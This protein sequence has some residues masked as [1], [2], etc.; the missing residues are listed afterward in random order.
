MNEK[1]YDEK[2]APLLMEA[3]RLCEQHGLGFVAGVEYGPGEYGSTATFPTGASLAMRMAVW[4]LECNGNF[5]LFVIK[6]RKWQG[7]RPHGSAVLRLIEGM[8]AKS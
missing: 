7:D 2:I 5:D 8:E 1:I 4:A 6:L 3:G